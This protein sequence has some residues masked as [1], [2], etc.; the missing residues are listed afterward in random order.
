[1]TIVTFGKYAGHS[2][3]T[4]IHMLGIVHV[5]VQVNVLVHAGYT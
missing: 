2:T 4:S 3:C 1:M 5:L